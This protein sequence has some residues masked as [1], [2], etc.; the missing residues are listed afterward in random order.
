MSLVPS[1]LHDLVASGAILP[2]SS[3]DVVRDRER[4]VDPVQRR[5]SPNSEAG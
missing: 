3:S 2:V 5:V 1:C 4:G